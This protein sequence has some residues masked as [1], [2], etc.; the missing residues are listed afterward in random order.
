MTAS[1]LLKTLSCLPLLLGKRPNPL[2]GP[3]K[4][5]STSPAS[6]QSIL[7]LY[8]PPQAQGFERCPL[9]LDAGCF[10]ISS[11]H[12][13]SPDEVPGHFWALAQLPGGSI[14]AQFTTNICGF[15]W[16]SWFDSHCI[17]SAPTAGMGEGRGSPIKKRQ[18][19][20]NHMG[21]QGHWEV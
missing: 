6:S 12:R 18:E 21:R 19:N 14:R 20:D 4:P 3:Q 8:P 15:R 1:L 7:H 11:S 9:H 2:V 13:H 16:A 10:P 17:P 5:P